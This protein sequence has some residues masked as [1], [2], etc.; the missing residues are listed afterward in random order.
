MTTAFDPENVL[1]LPLVANLATCEIDGSPRNAPVWFH[2]EEGALHMLSDESS[3]SM[4][5]VL[6]DPRVAVEI[7]DY[8]NRQ[9]IMRHLGLRGRATVEAMNA[10]LFRRLLSRYLG[11]EEADWNPWF[12]E[13]VARISDPSGR[14]IRLVPDSVFT[15]NVSF[16]RTGPA[17]ATS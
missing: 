12:V 8:D 4:R 1:Q 13:S 6:N 11:P 2:W 3:S 9:G 15:N 10:A 7:I 14:L 16:F 5:R 17:L